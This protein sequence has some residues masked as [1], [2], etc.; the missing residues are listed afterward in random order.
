LAGTTNKGL[1]GRKEEG[2]IQLRRKREV[3]SVP[4]EHEIVTGSTRRG[5]DRRGGC[6]TSGGVSGPGAGK[7]EEGDRGKREEGIFYNKLK[8]I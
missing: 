6:N 2:D 8:I 5:E 3:K 4:R 1:L 7:R